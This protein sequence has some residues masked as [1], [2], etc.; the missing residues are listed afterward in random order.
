MSLS[1]DG[2]WKAGVWATTVWANGVWREGAAPTPT[3]SPTPE[4]ASS[5]GSSLTFEEWLAR[6]P[7]LRDLEIRPNWYQ[8]PA[9]KKKVKAKLL[10]AA[11]EKKKAER[12]LS[13]AKGS[14]DLDRLLALLAEAQKRYDEMLA[15]YQEGIALW[16]RARAAEEEEEEEFIEFLTEFLS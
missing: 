3:P 4:T 12:R 15:A 10:A 1:I 9:E 2:V 16:E 6:H 8:Y 13:F 7:W 11:R 14:D 5:G